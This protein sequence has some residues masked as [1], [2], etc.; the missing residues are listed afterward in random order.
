MA[1][2]ERVLL[3][4]LLSLI[5]PTDYTALSQ[6]LTFQPGTTRIS[7]EISIENDDIV[8]S[9][10]NFFAGLTLETPEANVV[11]DPAGAEIRINDTD[12]EFNYC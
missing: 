2:N 3:R 1:L 8:E 11:V 4:L 9:V 7:V 5:A 10:E 6:T 12:S